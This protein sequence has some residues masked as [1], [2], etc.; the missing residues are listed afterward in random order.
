M[1][2]ILFF[3]EWAVRSSIF[4]LAGALLLLILRV[5]NPS[6]RLT[7]WTAI[8]AGSPDVARVGVARWRQLS[9]LSSSAFMMCW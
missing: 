8:L 3:G 9:R 6:V 4:I 5:K 1:T 7:A 2:T